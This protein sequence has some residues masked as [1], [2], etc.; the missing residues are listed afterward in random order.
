M[1]ALITQSEW[2]ILYAGLGVCVVIGIVG[3]V[4]KTCVSRKK[5]GK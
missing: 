5:Q 2:A 1:I 4:W 3:G